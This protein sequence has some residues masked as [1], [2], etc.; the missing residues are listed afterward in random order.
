M[1]QQI[2]GS[3]C[4]LRSPGALT[5]ARPTR[6]KQ[7]QSSTLH[8]PVARFAAACCSS[9]RHVGLHK[10]DKARLQNIRKPC[11]LPAVARQGTSIRC[12]A[13]RPSTKQGVYSVGK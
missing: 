6:S 9:A 12:T 13:S 3:M 8:Q 11:T 2:S 10:V 7:A 1:P 5:Q 4:S